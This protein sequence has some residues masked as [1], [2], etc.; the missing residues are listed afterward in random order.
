MIYK[1][2]FELQ[3]EVQ[4]IEKD[5][6]NP[7][8]K[9]KYFDIN[10]IISTL[11]PL[12]KKLDLVILQPLE[13]VENKPVLRTIILEVGS[14]EKVET[15]ALLP[16]G[17]EPQKMGS[18]ITYYRRYSLQSLLLLEAEDDDGT[19]GSPANNGYAPRPSKAPVKPTPKSDDPF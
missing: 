10:K 16:E 18:A 15:V 14:G 13:L 11:K 7:H 1:K 2:L 17:L 3:Q 6:E 4:A 19:A 5:S 8:F 9:S 12:L